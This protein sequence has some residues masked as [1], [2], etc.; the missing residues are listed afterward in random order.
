MVEDEKLVDMLKKML[1]MRQFELGIADLNARGMVPYDPHLY[2]GE[3]AVAAGVCANLRD[4]DYI[5]GTYRSHAHSIA[6][7]TPLPELAAEILAK[8][9][10]LSE[11]RGGTMRPM[12][13]KGG[14]LYPCTIVG[15]PIPIA[16]GA[17][18]AINLKKTGR[19]VAC[20]FGDGAVNIG[21]FHE[22]L[23]LASIWKAPVVYVCENNG[24]AMST[25]F[26]R[27]AS[28]KSVADRAVAYSITGVSVD[29]MDPVAVYEAARVAVERAR[30][31]QGPT[32]MEARTY[33]FRG[34]SESDVA[35][36]SYRTK[37]EVEE[38]KKR[39][40]IDSLKKKLLERGVLSEERCKQI[41]SEISTDVQAALKFA[42]DSPYPTTDDLF[43]HIY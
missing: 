40:P 37:E 5:I 4:D 27:A 38:W 14:V 2:I 21:G 7:G 34:H 13:P 19:V 33:R 12:Y 31:G 39:D 29:G 10:G 18:L 23:N 11:G 20:F 26:A 3:E 28:V 43:K 1:R 16:A 8:K 17:G 22:G 32:L 24:F 6:K 36:W 35:P 42:A 41:E 9:T 30:K 15:A 25:S